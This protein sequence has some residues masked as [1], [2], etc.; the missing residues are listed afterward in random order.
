MKV[1]K[2]KQKKNTTDMNRINGNLQSVYIIIILY[3]VEFATV[4]CSYA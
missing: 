2:K 1:V 4:K 3:V